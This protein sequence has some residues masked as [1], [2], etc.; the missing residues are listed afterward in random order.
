MVRAPTPGPQE[1]VNFS[2]PQDQKKAEEGK[3]QYYTL[4]FA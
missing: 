2:L 1:S 4:K 3:V